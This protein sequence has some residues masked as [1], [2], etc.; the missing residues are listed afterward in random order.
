MTTSKSPLR[1]V[2][3]PAPLGPDS[4]GPATPPRP[5][6]A[7]SRAGRW[8]AVL[9]GLLAGGLA[10][11]VATFL[12]GAMSFLGMSTGTPSPIAAIGGAF[13]DRTPP[14]LKTFAIA[15]F[16][17]HDKTALLTGM[18]VVLILLCAGVGVLARTRLTPALITLAVV[19]AVGALAVSSRPHAG[20]LDVIPTAIGTVAGIKLLQSF[21]QADDRSDEGLTRRRMLAGAGALVAGFLGTRFD[22]GAGQAT[23]S[24][25]ATPLPKPIGPAPS[26]AGASLDIPG[27]APYIVPN[28]AFYRIDTAF[29]VPHLEAA[30]W[31][32][33]VV[34]EVEQEI[35]LDWATLLTKPLVQK[36]VTL[37]CVS[38]EVGGDLVGNAVWT[39]WPVRELLAMARPKAGADMV[40]STS[41]DG[42]TAG[43]PIGAL[44]DDRDALLAVAMNGE[45]LPFEHGYPVRLVVPGLYGYVSAT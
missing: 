43:T 2:G 23:D 41:S 6:P 26:T 31:K 3:S 25:A 30:T 7:D 22:S 8:W 15:T 29:V 35:S 28:D 42:F 20:A 37:T 44:T 39:G 12:G 5:S 24:R 18:V 10:I 38:N 1:D 21:R 14:W 40:L 9:D 16:G 34:G 19:G 36:M 32:L 11:A 27:V 33:R 45:P 13:I 4:S 17:T